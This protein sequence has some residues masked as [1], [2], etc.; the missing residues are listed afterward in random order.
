MSYK[1]VQD[2]LNSV[3]NGGQLKGVQSSQDILNAIYDESENAIRI[4]ISGWDGG[5]GSGGGGEGLPVISGNTPPSGSTKGEKGQVYIDTSA[6]KIYVC[7]DKN[8]SQCQWEAFLLE[9]QKNTANGFAG[10][11]ENALVSPDQLPVAKQNSLGGVKVNGEYGITI[12]A[13]GQIQVVSANSTEIGQRNN[14]S[15]PIVP[16]NLNDA[17][18]ASITDENHITL[19]AEQQ[20]TAQEVFNVP[21]IDATG[22][23]LGLSID[24]QT[25]VMTISLK[26]AD[27]ETLDTKTVDLPLETMVVSASCSEGTLTL[28]LQSGETVD[29]DVSSM[30]SGFISSSEKGVANGVA[31]LGSDGTIPTSQLPKIPYSLLTGEQLSIG[32]QATITVNDDDHIGTKSSFSI[33]EDIDQSEATASVAVGY[34]IDQS[35]TVNSMAIGSFINQQQARRSLAVGVELEAG[36]KN[37]GAVYFGKYNSH[38][39][40]DNSLARITG[41]G[42]ADDHRRNIEELSW[43][44]DFYI[45]G[46]HQQGV[47]FISSSV[48]GYDL[49]EGSFMHYVLSYCTYTL[50]AVDFDPSHLSPSDPQ[51]MRTREVIL[52]VVFVSSNAS[53]S[54]VDSSGNEVVPLSTPEIEEHAYVCYL[55]RFTPAMLKWVILPVPM[56][57]VPVQEEP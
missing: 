37:G 2:I 11:D 8:G 47:T 21:D 34:Q 56:G 13:N 33:G 9:S 26:N 48:T 27:G 57:K 50:P 22:T 16:A 30:V 52:D 20:A 18:I 10:L 5:G 14:Q 24:P 54:F 4:N 15:K 29:V 32:E 41:G 55:C 6:R 23:S 39:S 36:G 3:F 49:S 28:T 35:S 12:T 19:N 17:V 53:V 38:S 25:Y 43:N 44:G 45:T 7:I 31:S 1:S 40:E 51:L 42:D 46:G